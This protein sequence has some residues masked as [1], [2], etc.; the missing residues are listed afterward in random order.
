VHQQQ[1]PAAALPQHRLTTVLV[2]VLLQL[3]SQEQVLAEHAG[4]D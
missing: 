1:Q 2:Q 4:V 3:A